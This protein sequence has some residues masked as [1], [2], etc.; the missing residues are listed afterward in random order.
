MSHTLSY[1]SRILSKTKHEKRAAA[2]RLGKCHD[3]LPHFSNIISPPLNKFGKG[4]HRSVS[5][6]IFKK[7]CLLSVHI[8]APC[9]THR[10][11]RSTVSSPL[12][13]LPVS[14]S[15]SESRCEALRAELSRLK[16]GQAEHDQTRLEGQVQLRKLHRKLTLVT[17]V[18]TGGRPRGRLAAVVIAVAGLCGVQ[19]SASCRFT[20]V[21]TVCSTVL[22]WSF[23]DRMF[24]KNVSTRKSFITRM[25][26]I[27][28]VWADQH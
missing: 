11:S 26:E 18:S 19:V 4:S 5:F 2:I 22:L 27:G 9:I 1:S 12:P 28:A 23:I 20:V 14:L 24:H 16:A 10:S 17:M 6:K 8:S 25:V 7:K 3:Y 15:A 21:T 13:S